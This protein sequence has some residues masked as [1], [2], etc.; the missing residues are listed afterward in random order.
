LRKGEMETEGKQEGSEISLNGKVMAILK[1]EGGDELGWLS[2][3]GLDDGG[4]RVVSV[5][6]VVLPEKLGSGVGK[7]LLSEVAFDER[8]SNL[9]KV[10]ETRNVSFRKLQARVAWARARAENWQTSS[11]WSVIRREIS[12]SYSELWKSGSSDESAWL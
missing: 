3:V 10:D 9:Q 1:G 12:Q 5:S 8:R 4:L 11:S 7:R 6:D 2:E